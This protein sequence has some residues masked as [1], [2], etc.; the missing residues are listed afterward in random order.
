MSNSISIETEIVVV[1]ITEIREYEFNNQ[2]HEENRVDELCESIK[3]FGFK[4]P[5]QVDEDGVILCGHKRFYAAQ[6]LEMMKVPVM[7]VRNLDDLQKRAYRIFD[8]KSTKD[9]NYHLHNLDLELNYMSDQG[10]DLTPL[11]LGELRDI[12]EKEEPEVEEDEAPAE[13]SEDELYIALGDVIE[14]GRHRVVCGDSTDP[15]VVA[16]CQLDDMSPVLMVT[17]PPYGVE[18]DPSFRSDNPKKQGKVAN[19]DEWNWEATW[20]SWDSDIAY[21]W[22]A[23]KF[24]DLVLTT[25]RT[26][27]YEPISQI[28]WAKDRFAMSRGD[29][30]WKHEPCW[31]TVKKGKKHNWQGARDQHT[32]WEIK[33]REDDGH[34]HGTQ[35]PIECMARPIRNNTAPGEIVCD[36]FLG[37]GTTLIAAE[38]LGRTCIGT[39]IEPKYCQVII[40][41]YRKYCEKN[42]TPFECTI[43]GHK[44]D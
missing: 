11:G 34:G 23:G 36:P 14:L 7:Y 19:D 30:H 10:F 42:N 33:A 20:Q 1:P 17:D 9:S 12:F 27:G 3:S 44:H 25:L 13:P 16:I 37:S 41:R 31:Y 5:I 39:E 43:N 35:K 22:H 2:K 32:L 21:V 28:I 40:E 6:K 8:N 24:T 18:Y 38:Q 15:D 4:S 26:A 29:Y